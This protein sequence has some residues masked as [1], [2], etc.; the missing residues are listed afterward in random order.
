MN[1]RGE[2]V[3]R[4]IEWLNVEVLAIEEDQLRM[5]AYLDTVNNYTYLELIAS[6]LLL[7]IYLLAH[8]LAVARFSL[9]YT[10]VAQESLF[11]L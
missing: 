2:V 5:F 9:P 6:S 1:N 8:L 4:I 11:R 3:E 7:P 10:L